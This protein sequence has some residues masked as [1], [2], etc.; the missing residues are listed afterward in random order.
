MSGKELPP[1]EASA[2]EAAEPEE[3]NPENPHGM[4]D[5]PRFSGPPKTTFERF[6]RWAHRHKRAIYAVFFLAIILSFVVVMRG[7]GDSRPDSIVDAYFARFAGPDENW[8]YQIERYNVGKAHLN[9]LFPV[10]AKLSYGD[11]GA[12][13]VLNDKDTFDSFVREQ[14][15]TDLLLFAAIQS[16]MLNDAEARMFMENAVRQAAADYYL[17]KQVGTEQTDFRVNISDAQALAYYNQNQAYYE[18]T[19]LERGQALGVIKNTLAGLR[20]DQLRQQLAIERNR[21]VGALK[22]QIGPRLNQE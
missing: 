9:N 15:E 10:L 16:G 2:E 6:Q 7:S 4:Y 11:A 22:D 17:Y 13:A 3:L 1:E 18:S 14:Y 12:Q 19:G 21:I 5:S 8:Q 20:R